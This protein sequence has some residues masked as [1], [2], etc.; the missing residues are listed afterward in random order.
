MGWKSESSEAGGPSGSLGGGRQ[1]IAEA[2]IPSI[3]V[4]MYERQIG[5]VWWL[6]EKLVE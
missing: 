2:E 1:S 6:S 5:G 4:L 3:V